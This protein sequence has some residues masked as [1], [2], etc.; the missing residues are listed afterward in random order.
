M[1]GITK[2]NVTSTI[3][4]RSEIITLCIFS[5]L[6][7]ASVTKYSVIWEFEGMQ[8]SVDK[9]ETWQLF[10]ADVSW[11]LGAGRV[12]VPDLERSS[13]MQQQGW[14]S[15]AG[16]LLCVWKSKAPN[17]LSRELVH[18]R[19]LWHCFLL[20]DARLVFYLLFSSFLN[21]LCPVCCSR[22]RMLVLCSL[23]V[24]C[25]VPCSLSW[26]SAP[27]SLSVYRVSSIPSM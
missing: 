9:E 8:T 11:C 26:N 12:F 1:A 5:R 23:Q 4:W 14:F 20:W 2:W 3:F 27:K 10:I 19:I 15:V 24:G 13:K 22:Q 16:I 18:I 17:G 25:S 21:E 7:L 6:F